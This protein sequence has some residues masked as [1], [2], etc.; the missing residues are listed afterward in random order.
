[1]YLVDT[2]DGDTFPVV[3]NDGEEEDALNVFKEQY[4]DEFHTNIRTNY[5]RMVKPYMG[6]HDVI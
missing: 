2:I 6:E 3:M 1:M 5:R 4:P